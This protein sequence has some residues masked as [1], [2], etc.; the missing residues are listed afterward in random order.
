[1]NT[2]IDSEAQETSFGPAL[3]QLKLG[4]TITRKLWKEPSKFV[5]LIKGSSGL[6]AHHGYGFGEYLNEPSFLDALF[7]HDKDKSLTPWSVPHS[8]LL[9]TDWIV[10]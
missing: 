4:R 10:L 1:M 5:L 3:E 8:D 2:T 7:I 6:A 9:A